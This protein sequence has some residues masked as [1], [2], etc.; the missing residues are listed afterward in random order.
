[1]I[2]ADSLLGVKYVAALDAPPL[3]K[4]TEQQSTWESRELY[5]NPY[6]LPLGFAA[7]P[8]I[9]EDIANN[10]NPFLYQ[11]EFVNSLTGKEIDCLVPIAPIMKQQSTQEISWVIEAPEDAVVFGYF[12]RPNRY[13]NIDLIVNRDEGY[14]FLTTWSQG[15]FYVPF[16]SETGGRSV[17]LKSNDSNTVGEQRFHAVY[18]DKTALEN[19]HTLLSSHPLQVDSMVDG[20]LSG[21]YLATEGTILFTTIPYDRGWTILVDGEP[22]VPS[23]SQGTFIALELRPGSHQIE[24]TYQ[25][26]GMFLGAI[27]SLIAIVLFAVINIFWFNRKRGTVKSLSKL[28][29]ND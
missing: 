16:D 11:N 13:P 12:E 5:E 14:Q 6:A 10:G 26:P 23:I 15:M 19:A 20:Y 4:N 22:V 18:V 27:V 21:S 1:M 2:V 7:N 24:M 8:K 3:Y 29:R 17:T 9:L 25:I 28:H